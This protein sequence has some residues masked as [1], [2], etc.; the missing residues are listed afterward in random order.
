[1]E[2]TVNSM[3][4]IKSTNNITKDDI[5]VTMLWIYI[6]EIARYTTASLNEHRSTRLF[7][8]LRYSI[9]INTILTSN[10]RSKLSTQDVGI[11]ITLLNHQ[12]LSVPAARNS[13]KSTGGGGGCRR[14]HNKL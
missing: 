12:S 11:T 5:G 7:N 4:C 6:V 3:N 9:N 1:M 8:I 14:G 10:F 13:T 2:T